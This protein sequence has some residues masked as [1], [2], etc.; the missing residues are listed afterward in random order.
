MSFPPI[1]VKATNIDLSDELRTLLE[2]KF[3]SLEKFVPDNET[4]LKC[5]AELEK[6]TNH[7]QSGRIYRAEVNLSVAGKLYRAEATEEQIEQAI[8]EVRDE[9]KRELRKAQDKRR[10]MVRRGG[11][12]IKRMMRFG[13]AN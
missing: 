12:A 3:S 11:Q 4:D 9:L 6:V 13:R 7:H 10:S 8:D 1:N 2:E 5:E